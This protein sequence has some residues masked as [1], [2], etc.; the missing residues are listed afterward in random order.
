METITYNIMSTP[1]NFPSGNP[2]AYDSG[3]LSIE[4]PI[5]VFIQPMLS[6]FAGQA[7][8]LF[9][10]PI[11]F[12]AACPFSPVLNPRLWSAN[13]PT[14]I[15]PP[16]A[17]PLPLAD[18]YK[19]PSFIRINSKEITNNTTETGNGNGDIWIVPFTN[20]IPTAGLYSFPYTTY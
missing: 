5:S 15:N 20:F 6:N 8:E 12:A 7:K 16:P 13:G 18:P 19:F 11:H 3:S 1:P 14:P 2:N 17:P 9:F 4:N 10:I